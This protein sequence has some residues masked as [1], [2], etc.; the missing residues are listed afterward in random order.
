MENT[1][2]IDVTKIE[3]FYGRIFVNGKETIDPMLI[4]LALMDYAENG[5]QK[6]P[7][8]QNGIAENSFDYDE[9][10]YLVHDIEQL[11]R[12]ITAVII[13]K[14]QILYEVIC[15]TVVSQ[16]QSSELTKTKIVY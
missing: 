2:E 4:G 1:T 7:I 15:G 9:I 6:L 14:T 13:G 16:H 5:G 10:V 11:P 8:L 12:M 3:I